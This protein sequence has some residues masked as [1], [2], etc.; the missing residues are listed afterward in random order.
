MDIHKLTAPM[1]FVFEANPWLQSSIFVI[2]LSVYTIC[3][4]KINEEAQEILFQGPTA[5]SASKLVDGRPP[6]MIAEDECVCH[7]VMTRHTEI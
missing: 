7:I 2:F 5:E 6:G 3:S 4:R 1:P